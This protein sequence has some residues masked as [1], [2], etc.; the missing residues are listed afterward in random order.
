MKVKRGSKYKKLLLEIARCDEI[1]KVLRKENIPC[2]KIIKS[3]SNYKTAYFQVPEPWSGHLNKAPIL[4]IGSNPSI[5]KNSKCPTR[6]NND[7]YI[8]DFFTK[9][10]IDKNSNR[11][12]C[13][14]SGMVEEL[15][16]K[17]KIQQ[18]KNKYYALTEVVH[19]KSKG[20]KGVKEARLKCS[21]LYLRDIVKASNAKVVVVL[22]KKAKKVIT[23]LLKSEWSEISKGIYSTLCGNYERCLVFLSHPSPANTHSN[24]AKTFTDAV[25]KRVINSE[26]LELLKKMVKN[27]LQ[28]YF[29]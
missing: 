20:E 9:R 27:R 16:P 6:N 5:S 14:V 7:K 4:F 8:Y 2:A 21:E 23:K 17:K 12:W 25:K 11:Y 15:L 3:Q 19:C 1:E 10:L 22:G 24:A 18:D 13:A 28:I 29:P 26:G